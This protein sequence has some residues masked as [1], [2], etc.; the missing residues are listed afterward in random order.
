MRD[1]ACMF[2]RPASVCQSGKCLF[3]AESA[4]H[5]SRRG[6]ILN[7][8]NFQDLPH[9][10]PGPESG[11]VE[12]GQRGSQRWPGST[13]PSIL[14]GYSLDLTI[15]TQ[16]QQ[17]TTAN[18]NTLSL[19]SS[20][21]SKAIRKAK[22]LV[23]PHCCRSGLAPCPNRNNTEPPGPPGVRHPDN[24]DSQSNILS[25]HQPVRRFIPLRMASGHLPLSEPEE[26]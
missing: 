9:R 20:T 18:G 11:Q 23:R 21:P 1:S 3:P 26:W 10:A 15:I 2:L 12:S 4:K 5:R 13:G 22:T 7:H 24:P 17:P 16:R 6:F 14:P 25:T 19:R 8:K